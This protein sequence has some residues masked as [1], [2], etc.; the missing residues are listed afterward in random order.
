MKKGVGGQRSRV[1]KE[2]WAPFVRPEQFNQLVAQA[3]DKLPKKYRAL[4]ENIAV[5]VEERPAAEPGEKDHSLMGEF[6][7][8]PRTEKGAWDMAAE[9]D[10]VVLYRKN[11]EAYAKELVAGEPHG[12]S[13]EEIIREEVRLTVLHEL[14]HY[15][16]LEEEDLEDV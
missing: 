2:S 8:V 12:P 1:R 7:G 6:L 10:R 11:I 3:L 13:V 14:G 4:L 9:P 16:G 5:I 15:F